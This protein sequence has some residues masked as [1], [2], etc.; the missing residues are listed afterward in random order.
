MRDYYAV[1]GVDKKASDAE[2]KK[3][4]RKKAMEFHPDRNKGDAKAEEKFKELNEAYAVLSDKKKRQ[5][6]D[7][8]GAQGFR[9]RFS[10]EDIFRDFN[11]N[12]IIRDFGFNA[13]G[14]DPF[15]NMEQFFRGHNPFGQSGPQGGGGFR[16]SSFSMKGSN[17]EQE[18]PITLE[19][20]CFGTEKK[21]NIRRGDSLEE[22]TVKIPAGIEDGKKLR[23][24]GKG[25][26]NH[27]GSNSGDLLLKIKIKPHSTFKRD[28]NNLIVSQEI[29][30][31]DAVL[32]TSIEVPT[33]NGRIMV[34]VPPGTQN[35]A[36]LRL[37]E[38]GVP[39]AGGM[40]KGDQ[41]VQIIVKIPKALTDEQEQLFKQLKETGL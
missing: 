1:L 27:M 39:K 22:T 14:G 29:G 9:Q 7:M 2:I 24:A 4:F 18:F 15:K 25:Y 23:L 11:M 26:K 16:S 13:G 3:A 33:L 36:K 12:D 28:G 35:N 20:A 31:L 34:K 30:L 21:L 6:Y 37:K 19:E 32:G 41:L 38:L 8:F 5:Q 17:I 40:Y 10:Q